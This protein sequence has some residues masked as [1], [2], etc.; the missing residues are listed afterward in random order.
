MVSPK[1]ALECFVGA[2]GFLNSTLVN[3]TTGELLPDWHSPPSGMSLWTPNGYNALIVTANDTTEPEKRPIELT[4]PASP[5]DSDSRWALVGKYSIAGGG[6]FHLSNVTD[7]CSKDRE[8]PA[9]T[10]TG[11]FL[12]ATLPSRIGPYTFTFKFYDHCKVWNLR[13]RVG[14]DKL[15]VAWYYKLPD[16][17]NYG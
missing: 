7:G 2:W 11:T 14:D 3:T 15:R 5:S 12:T 17:Y 9:G 16:I 6:P 8:G 1:N 13:Q 4:Q 10:V